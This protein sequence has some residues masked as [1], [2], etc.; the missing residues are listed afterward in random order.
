MH[1][2]DGK[3]N[4]V[5]SKGVV[6]RRKSSRHIVPV[7]TATPFESAKSVY[8]VENGNFTR[9]INIL[10]EGLAAVG[11]NGCEYAILIHLIRKTYGFSKKN[12]EISISQFVKATGFSARMV[13]KALS[14]LQ[15]VNIIT[16]VRR[17]NSKI[18]SNIWEINKYVNTW[19]T[20]EL[21]C[22]SAL[23]G[24]QLV[25]Y[26]AYTK[27]IIKEITTCSTEQA[28]LA[29]NKKMDYQPIDDDGNALVVKKRGKSR[30]KPDL[31]FNYENQLQWLS[32]AP[33]TMYKIIALYWAMKNY[34][35]DNWD[36]YYAQLS[37]DS[38]PAKSL[39]GY[40]GADLTKAMKYCQQH[41][42]PIKADGWESWTLESVG[43]KVADLINKK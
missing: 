3:N 20:T 14:R 17:G 12:D 9:I 29:N 31:P 39:S 10:L 5:D 27:E 16:L 42:K 23:F 37:R 43:K 2:N 6:V 18:S 33:Q 25:N 32:K 24:N 36:Q 28:L 11:L 19:R 38:K 40:S 21:K 15:L 22:T 30:F 4:I 26:S 13:L 41:T 7:Q 34:R 35:F 1:N 8:Q